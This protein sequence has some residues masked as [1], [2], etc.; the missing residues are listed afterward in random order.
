MATVNRITRNAAEQVAIRALEYLA[1]D[2]ERLGRF[3][4]LSGLGPQTIRTAARDR[5][6]LAGILEY[7]TGDERLL[8]AFAATIEIPPE[9]VVGAHAILAGGPWERDTA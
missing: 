6:F 8:V 3:L 5:Q 9:H 7:V 4:A 1:A 2:G